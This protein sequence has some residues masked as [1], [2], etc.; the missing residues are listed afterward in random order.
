MFCNS[1]DVL[2]NTEL[3]S[4]LLNELSKKKTSIQ[5]LRFKRCGDMPEGDDGK[6]M[7]PAIERC[8]LSGALPAGLQ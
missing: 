6:E 4:K 5:L 1:F 2:K 3:V 7:L 8:F